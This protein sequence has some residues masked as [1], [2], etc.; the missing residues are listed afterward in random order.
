[1][2]ALLHFLLTLRKEANWMRTSF[3]GN[4]SLICVGVT[5]HCKICMDISLGVITNI[6]YF[7]LCFIVYTSSSGKSSDRLMLCICKTPLRGADA[8]AHKS[9]PLKRLTRVKVKQMLCLLTYYHSLQGLILF[10]ATYRLF[11]KHTAE[12]YFGIKMGL[13]WGVLIFLFLQNKSASGE[14][15]HLIAGFY[16]LL[17]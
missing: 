1:M 7:F 8:V 11:S 9:R 13:G 12:I 14:E 2:S 17:P 16:A 15:W 10:S 5:F 6:P 3:C 4:K